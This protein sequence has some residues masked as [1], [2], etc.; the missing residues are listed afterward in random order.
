[1]NC[2]DII[3][4]VYGYLSVRKIEK[5]KEIDA[6]INDCFYELEKLNSFK[7]IYVKQLAKLCFL[8]K[9]PYLSFILGAD[10][11]FLVAATLGV[12]VDRLIKRYAVTDMMRAIVLDATANAYLEFKADEYEKTLGENLSYRFCPGYQGSSVT[13]LKYI[14]PVLKPEKIGITLLESGMMIPQKS[15]CGIIAIGKNE[16]K[17][18]G[19]CIMLDDCSFRKGGKRC[20]D[21]EKK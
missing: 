7:Y 16:K 6:L 2:S 13:D 20:Y 8:D 5:N 12:E 17:R 21:L 3:D 15:M 19:D 11:Y 14:F 1:M 4:A 9:E 10:A 18:C